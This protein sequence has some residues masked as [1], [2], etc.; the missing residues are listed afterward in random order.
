MSVHKAVH[1]HRRPLVALTGTVVLAASALVAAPASAGPHSAG[2][3]SGG[4][5]GAGGSG[6]PTVIASGLDSP[7]LLSFGP[8]GALY[9]PEAGSGGSGPCVAGPT[10]RVCFGRTGALT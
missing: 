2:S 8:H 9:V 10:G 7:R 4:S 1:N 5:G 6:G 3:G